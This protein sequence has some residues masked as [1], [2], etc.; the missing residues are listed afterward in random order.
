MNKSD[1]GSDRTSKVCYICT[2]NRFVDDHHLDCMEGKL[3]PETVP[4]CRRCHRTFHDLGVEW[5]DDE[6]LD[7]AIE[8]ENRRREIVYSNLENPVEPLVLLNREDIKRTYYF[9]KKHGIKGGRDNK[10]TMTPV[11]SF[12]LP[13]GEPLCGWDWV[14][15]H[16]YDLMDWV[17]RIEVVNSGVPLLSADIDNAKK[18]K[19]T[20]KSLR[21]IMKGG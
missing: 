9:N 8:L 6:F 13:H 10:G 20:L 5:F 4:L 15:A 3:S 14:N 2:S 7:K 21:G 18:Y 17:P 1:G 19:D 12:K 11:L 16:M